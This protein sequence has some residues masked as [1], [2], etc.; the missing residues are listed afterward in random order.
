MDHPNVVDCLSFLELVL[1]AR[2]I[3]TGIELIHYGKQVIVDDGAD[4]ARHQDSDLAVRVQ[5]VEPGEVVR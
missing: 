2:G 5:K 3:L 4:L 1:P